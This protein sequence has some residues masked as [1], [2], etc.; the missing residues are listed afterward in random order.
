MWNLL[1]VLACVAG[2]AFFSA[3]ETALTRIAPAKAAHLID[4]D[5]GKNGILKLWVDNRRRILAG[6]LIGNNLVNIL[7]SVLAYRMAA[8]FLGG[9]AEAVSVLGMTLII[10]VFAEITPKSLAMQHA[11][12]IAV[13]MLRL[14]WLLDKMLYPLSWLLSGALATT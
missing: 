8:M 13:P 3:A 14:I 1:G 12:R 10:L 2:S 5:P 9:Y 7:A 4:A 6:L 11:E